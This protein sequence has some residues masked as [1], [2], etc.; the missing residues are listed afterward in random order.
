MGDL[1]GTQV[2][3][4]RSQHEQGCR[5]RELDR[6]DALRRVDIC[7][8]RDGWTQGEYEEV[9]G[10]LG[11]RLRDNVTALGHDDPR[12]RRRGKKRWF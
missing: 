7:W 2:Q 3:L 1:H 9:V 8:Q 6:Q 5:L 10:A 11:L 4:L 12:R